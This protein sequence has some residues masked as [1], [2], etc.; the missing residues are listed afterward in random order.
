MVRYCII[1]A[2]R[3]KNP[4]YPRYVCGQFPDAHQLFIISNPTV[5][6][7]QQASKARRHRP[8]TRMRL[9]AADS[10]LSMEAL[11]SMVRPIFVQTFIIAVLLN[12]VDLKVKTSH[13]SVIVCAFK[14]HLDSAAL[15]PYRVFISRST[16]SAGGQWADA[17]SETVAVK[18]TAKL[19]AIT[20][21]MPKS[22]IAQARC[23]REEPQPKLRCYQNLL[24]R[25]IAA[26]SGMKSK[27]FVCV[28]VNSACSS[29]R[30]TLSPTV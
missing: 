10:K 28:A 5:R 25:G 22:A 12:V 1:T 15:D 20:A 21:V 18:D 19:G 26:C 27:A 6:S 16:C 9:C 23:S 29:N 24:F 14:V 3:I 11:F 13:Q 4:L 8:Y 2:A 17:V 30:F 7:S